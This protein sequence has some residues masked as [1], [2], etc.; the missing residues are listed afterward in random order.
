MTNAYST[1]SLITMSSS[2]LNILKILSTGES[3]LYL[4]R[5]VYHRLIQQTVLQLKINASK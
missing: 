3:F 2:Y 4:G 5:L 1:S